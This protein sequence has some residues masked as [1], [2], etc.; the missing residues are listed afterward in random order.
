MARYGLCKTRYTPKYRLGRGS[1]PGKRKRR[2]K[3]KKTDK[4]HGRRKTKR[5]T[6]RRK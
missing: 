4:H 3:K 6:K 1:K 2:K 5:R